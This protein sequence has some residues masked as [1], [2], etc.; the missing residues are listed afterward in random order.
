MRE[1]VRFFSLGQ[2]A[3]ISLECLVSLVHH[4][5][6]FVLGRESLL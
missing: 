5:P 6:L 2:L 4:R 1:S 3:M